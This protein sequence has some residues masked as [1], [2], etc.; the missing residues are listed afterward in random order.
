MKI[1]YIMPVFNDEES[2][3]NLLKVIKN[4]NKYYNNNFII[5]NDCST[6]K[7]NKLPNKNKITEIILKNNQGSQKAISIGLNYV[8]DKKISFD[9]LIVM[10]SDGEDKPSDIKR[11]IN[12]SK[13]N[14]NNLVIFA[15][16]KKRYENLLFKTLYF[17]YKALFR[18]LTGKN[19]DFGNYSC[20]PKN[21]LKDLINVPFIDF[22]YSAS[23]LNSKLKFDTILCD[24][25]K[26]YSGES[27][28]S[29]FGLFN[30][31]A[32]SLSIFL[33][34][35]FLRFICVFFIFNCFFL[36][37]Y[38]NLIVLQI[39]LLLLIIVLIFFT[40]LFLLTKIKITQ[41]NAINKSNYVAFIKDIKFI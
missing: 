24:K 12:L 14:K 38:N 23:I 17:L 39:N 34:K 32:K 29:Y 9:F 7:F 36:I 19:I 41:K 4:T 16:R 5:V 6:H 20:I 26:R 18:I 11:L 8:F 10:D 31:A 37:N 15:S 30:H 2:F 35:I 25:G 3:L 21:R 28:M 27:K 13:K 33:K 40:Y 22:H 1:I